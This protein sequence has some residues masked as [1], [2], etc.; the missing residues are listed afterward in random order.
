MSF[1]IVFNLDKFF[2]LIN[3]NKLLF[4]SLNQNFALSLQHEIEYIQ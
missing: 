1:Y 3:T 4:S 2:T